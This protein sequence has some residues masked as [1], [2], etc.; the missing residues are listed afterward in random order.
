MRLRNSALKTLLIGVGIFCLPTF[1]ISQDCEANAGQNQTI[2][3]GES[4][5]L[6]G[7]PTAEDAT[8]P[9]NYN[10]TNIP[11]PNGGLANPTVSPTSTTTYT[12][13]LSGGGCN[14]ED[15][16]V[17]ITVLPSP[18]ANFT[19]SPQNQCA[20]TPVTFTNTTTGCTNCTYLWNFGD[21]ASGSANTSTA[22]S[23]QHTFSAVGT[24]NQTYTVTLTVTGP[25]PGNCQDIH[26]MSVT[27]LRVPEP[28]LTD[29]ITNFAQC[30]GDGTFA[31]QVFDAST[32]TTNASYSINWGDNSATWSG[33]TAPQGLSHT[34]TGIDVFDLT[35]TIT[36]TNGCTA[37]ETF[38]VSNITNPAVGAGIDG[39]TQGCAPLDACFNIL[40]YQFNH[41]S[42]T[43]TVNFG[44]GSPVLNFTH[45]NLPSQICHSYTGSSCLSG[46]QYTFTITA[47]NNCDNSTATITPVRVYT[48]PQAA[49][50]AN[51]VPAC[52]NAPVS[53]QNT[54]ILG[55]N[56]NCSQTAVFTWSWGDGSPNTVVTSTA[57]QSHTYSAPGNYTVTLSAQ[58]T[59]GITTM[60]QVI[61]VETP[62]TPIFSVNTNSGCLPLTVNTTNT[63]NN[64]IPCNVNYSW[65]VDYTDLPCDPDNGSFSYVGGTNASSLSP[66]FQLTSVG[67]Y[68]I[69]LRM[70]NACGIFEDNEV[71]TVNTVPVVSVNSIATICSGNSVTPSALVDNCNLPITSYAWSFTGGT[72]ATS[73]TLSPGAINFSSPGSYSA[74]L[75]ATNACGPSTGSAPIT[76]LPPPIVSISTSTG[77]LSVCQGTSITLTASNAATYSWTPS[78]GLNTTNGS[79][80]TAAPN[81]TTTYTVT[82]TAGSCTDTE[83]ITI[84]VNPLPVPS[85]S[86]TF[87]MCV[88]ETEQLGVNVVGGTAPYTSYLWNNATSLNNATVANPISSAT[89]TTNYNVQVTDSNGC[90]GS[91]NVPLTV[92]PLPVVNAG[93]D[94]QLCNQPVPTNLTGF[95]PTTGGIGVWSG[96][97]VTPTGVFTPNGIGCV[98]LTYTFTNTTTGC[99]NSDVVQVCTIDPQPANGGPDFSVCNGNTPIA[100]PAGGTWSG[101][102]V[103]ANNFT[104]SSIGS[105]NLSFTVG[106]GSCQTSDA[107]T[108]TVLANPT[109]N[110]GTDVTGLC[111]NQSV[112]LNGTASSPNGNITVVNWSSA[113]GG[114]TNSNTL[115]PSVLP[116][117]ASCS[118]NLTV[119]D[120]AGCSAQDQVTVQISPLPVVNAGLDQTLCNQPIAVT[121]VGFTPAG[122]IWSAP[123]GIG[124]SGNTVTPQ[125]TGAYTLTYTY[126]NPTTGCTN[127]DQ[128][129]LTVI[130]PVTAN[131]GPDVELCLNTPI[132]AINPPVPGGTWTPNPTVT[133][134]GSFNPNTVGTYTLTYSIGSGTCLTSDQMN[135]TVNALPSVNLGPNA[136]ICLNE[137]TQINGVI[138][139]GEGPYNVVWNFPNSLS[140]PSLI[141]P[142]A[143]PSITTNYTAT[144]TDANQCVGTDNILIS[145]NS[146]PVVNAGNNLVLC[147]Q[148]ITEVL[149]GF[150]PTT[151]GVGTWSGP[152]ITNPNGQFVSPGVGTYWVYYEFTAG[153]N[154]CSNIDSIQITV[155]PPV[156]AN[157][158][159]N[160]TFC[161]NEPLFTF[162][163][164]TPATGGNWSGN[165]IVN[166]TAGIF[167]PS[168]AGVGVHTITLNFGQGTC[169]TTDQTQVQVLPLPTVIA[170]P[171]N[172]VCGNVLPFNMT[173]FTPA[174][175]GTWEGPGITNSVSGNFNPAIGP[176]TYSVFL[177]FEDPITG[178]AD[179]S[180]KS[181]TVSPVPTANF[182][183]PPLGC[184]N[185][186]AV[187]DN[188]STGAS[189]YEWN[190]GNGTI[191]NGFEPN[192]TYPDEGFFDVRLVATNGFG[193]RDT[194]IINNEIIDPPVASFNL[195]PADGCA[196]L[197]VT[198]ENNSTGQYV[199]YAWNLSIAT[200]ADET[201]NPLIYQQG[202]DVLA[203]PISLTV[204]NFCGQSTDNN[205]VT[206]NPQPVASFGTNMDVFC[207]PFTVLFNN[208]SVGNPDTFEWNFGDGS[209]NIFTEE[210]ISH[211]FF[212][213][214]IPVDY[215]IELYLS[216]ECGVDTTE[217]TITVLPNTVTAFFNT[218][219]TQGCSPLSVEFTDFSEGGNQISYEF[220]PG[221]FTGV[222]NPTYTF[223][224]AGNYTVYQYVD[225][226]CSYDTTQISIVVFPSP[227]VDFSVD[228]ANVCV[229]EGIN[230]IPTVQDVVSL[231]WDFGDGQNSSLSQPSHFYSGGGTYNVTLTGISDNLCSA[232]ITSPVVV[233]T[234]PQASFTIPD[235]VGCSP[236]N[237]CFSNTSSGSQFYE[238]DFG[239]GN[240]SNNQSPCFEY[241]NQSGAPV[242]YTVRLISTSLQLCTDTMFMDI[243]V[244]PQPVSQYVLSGTSSCTFP[245]TVQTSNASQY[246]NGYEW[247]INGNSISQSTNTVFQFDAVGV[248]NTTLIASNQFGCSSTST[249][250]FTVH[251]LPVVDFD[252]SNANGCV[253]LLAQFTNNTLGASTYN[254]EFGDG[255]VSN[256]ANPAYIYTVP[257]NYDVTLTATSDVGCSSE[258]T[259][260]EA[261]NA[262][263]V[264]VASIFLEPESTTIYEPTI[265]FVSTGTEA[266]TYRWNFGDGYFGFEPAMLHTYENGGTYG[267]SLEVESG[268]GCRDEAFATVTIEDIFNIYVPNAFTPDEDGINEV[269]LPKL[270]G[271]IF[272]EKYKFQIFDRW[273]TII[274]ET[275]DMEE[276]WTGSVRGGEYFAKDDVYNWQITVQLKGVE[277]PRLYSGHVYILR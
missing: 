75:T 243:I 55:F 167:N 261:V 156:F 146:L 203:Y 61:C 115:T 65:L 266:E 123:A 40:N 137:S 29:P 77:N 182:T 229:N 246:A 33:T 240:F 69:R 106:S 149:T 27:V 190:F 191:L 87:S 64:G 274:F 76:V 49:F 268:E 85:P 14:G 180:Y 9:V 132:F 138:T 112:Q 135:I 11:G 63:S 165:G 244:S 8:G 42:T 47:T 185:S 88:G 179:S 143:S 110:A 124:L 25:A 35:Y 233:Y 152:G 275:D 70:T 120:V 201:P 17:T 16:S 28:V 164:I 170:G 150:S 94:T 26:T 189:V 71:I 221:I 258:I 234:Q 95:S 257:G 175:G 232:S 15:D 41:E 6:G 39:G 255:S 54:S 148:P 23:P 13:N 238:W 158:G 223:T 206:V 162:T 114:I 93:P 231:T 2:C 198:F 277:D 122:G 272:V 134:N 273:G 18:N 177:W 196:P 101:S 247:L 197:E 209:P 151:G 181:I 19:A 36:G 104:P 267:I 208:T 67:T 92:N 73:N 214:T 213:D 38:F 12:V 160:L 127:S 68:T 226:G 128:I 237:A 262:F 211:V 81:S 159:P 193:C 153:G 59:C 82:G 171:N 4:V 109:V 99:T 118:Y 100:L 31:L 192:Y 119:A 52:V 219:I 216:N 103:V 254:W 62:P 136:S 249:I 125:N 250:P 98:N 84:T 147:D 172:T 199:T 121:L 210:P 235:I 242:L 252:I 187:I 102:N 245:V 176:G 218:N 276:P 251:P 10:W 228:D 260:N 259:L 50:T 269:F 195:L 90:I 256:Q 173:G 224:E 202:P 222:A 108:V 157:A 169:F 83:T 53:F 48:G 265:Y 79:S 139:G 131:A 30:S 217:Y 78:T 230:F 200:S 113:C 46:G 21:P 91:A 145:V 270:T 161:L 72:P 3:A 207:S 105:F 253:D 20:S 154:A 220:E 248:Y 107:V 178:C 117:G 60:S 168:I 37:S 264:P 43:Y 163:G 96:P 5:V 194:M 184:T 239:N 24:G 263:E 174:T 140:S 205:D 212:A 215:T 22:F 126:T 166:A 45:A 57:T 142:I 241:V 44:D 133:V 66:Q 86:G 32:P 51:P 58:N 56:N 204:S 271:K 155:N 89:S 236:F 141:N 188:I 225:N 80:V 227:V 186:N 97:N 111:A 116:V 7:N 1:A 74:T 129:I 34:Y 130:N 183:L 144:V